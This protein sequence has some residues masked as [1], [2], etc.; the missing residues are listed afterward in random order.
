MHSVEDGCPKRD[1]HATRNKNKMEHPGTEP[2]C[3]SSKTLTNLESRPK[4]S[5]P[6][7]PAPRPPGSP[8]TAGDTRPGPPR[9]DSSIARPLGPPQPGRSTRAASDS[10]RRGAPH[11]R[12]STTILAGKGEFLTLL[13]T[14]PLLARALSPPIV[15]SS[16]VRADVARP[17]CQAKCEAIS[18]SRSWI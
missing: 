18:N 16:P 12:P 14:L 7:R 11:H 1:G 13:Q 6:R 9:P 17:E 15:P 4:K 5:T 10:L 2:V 8:T 3:K